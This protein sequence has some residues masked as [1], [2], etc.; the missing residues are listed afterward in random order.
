MPLEDAETSLPV[1]VPKRLDE[2]DCHSLLSVGSAAQ[3]VIE[4]AKDQRSALG[5]FRQEWDQRFHFAVRPKAADR[6]CDRRRVDRLT[7]LQRFL[8]LQE[9]VCPALDEERIE[10]AFLHESSRDVHFELEHLTESMSRGFA[11][12]GNTLPAEIMDHGVDDRR[13]SRVLADGSTRRTCLQRKPGSRRHQQQPE[14]TTH[15]GFQ[16]ILINL[17]P[18]RL[19]LEKTW[20]PL[21][22]VERRIV[23]RPEGV[24]GRRWLTA[25]AT[26]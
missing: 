16:D 19:D 15:D 10:M 24:D 12:Q 13:P 11:E 7:G 2:V 14:H 21:R 17:G 20:R 25:G 4:T 5:L 9:S 26:A 22:I 23:T 6:R 18:F 3:L 8:N 1:A